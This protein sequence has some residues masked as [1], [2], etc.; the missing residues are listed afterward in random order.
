MNDYDNLK[1]YLQKETIYSEDTDTLF[2]S[3][4]QLL[5][6]RCIIKAGD[7]N[8]RLLEIEFYLYSSSH[9]DLITYPR[10]DSEGVNWFFHQSGVDICLYS[11][12]NCRTL[13]IIQ[14]ENRILYNRTRPKVFFSRFESFMECC[15]D[16]RPGLSKE[17]ETR[18]TLAYRL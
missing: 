11:S 8:Y 5:F 12:C 10:I 15:T 7:K 14:T 17:D 3:L 9:P 6:N 1:N 18:Q 4:A 2:S 16:V 13:F